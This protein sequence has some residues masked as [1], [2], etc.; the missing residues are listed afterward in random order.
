MGIRHAT[1]SIHV[2][3]SNGTEI[4]FRIN[5]IM[6]F[7]LPFSHFVRHIFDLISL[8]NAKKWYNVY[9]TFAADLNRTSLSM[10]C[11]F[12][13]Y[14]YSR[15]NSSIPANGNES[16]RVKGKVGFYE[17]SATA[18]F[19]IFNG[20]AAE[21]GWVLPHSCYSTLAH[22]LPFFLSSHEKLQSCENHETES[23]K[24]VAN[25][26]RICKWIPIWC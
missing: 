7:S 4:D 3:N 11:K 10:S 20:F 18:F 16:E 19:S 6:A 15:V 24:I 22:Y 26:L 9:M 2:S 12:T 1:E 17:N 14:R 25:Y 21:C 13:L 8:S 5:F 23:N